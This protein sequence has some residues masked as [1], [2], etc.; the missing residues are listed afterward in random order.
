MDRQGRKSNNLLRRQRELRGWTLDR[1]AEKLDQ[2]GGGTD[3]KQV[4]KWERGLVEPSPFYKEKLCLLY[5]TNAEELGFIVS[6]A[7]TNGKSEDDQK[8]H[9]DLGSND[10]FTLKRRELLNLLSV[11]G[12][13]LILLPDLD[14]ERI[15][16]AIKKPAQIDKET[17]NDL[18]IINA[19]YWSIY[20]IAPTKAIILDGVLGQLRTL[21]EFLKSPNEAIVHKQLC[22]LVSDLAQLAGEISFDSND[23]DAAQSCYIF[24]AEA[25]KE[26]RH[27][28]LWACALIRNAYLS[29]YSNKHYEAL[30]LL[31]AAYRL[32]LRGD[33]SLTTRYWFSAVEAEAQAGIQNLSACQKA[34]DLANEVLN[35]QDT[36]S[37][38]WLR[39]NGSRLTELNGACFVKLKE[40][41]LA[42]PV[43]QKALNQQKTLR[44]RGTVLTDLARVSLQK[45]EIDQA[46]FYA[47]QVILIANQ[48]NSGMLRKGLKDLQANLTPFSKVR[49]VKNLKQQIAQLG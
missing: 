40:P 33:S 28:D 7:L 14:W 9:Q 29:I 24:A 11:A 19:R 5:G 37:V 15:G 10:M 34:L 43:L 38:A 42:W 23:Y 36:S 25:A 39:F 22:I 12:T 2:L 20:Q 17:L 31:H 47:N 8:I 30:P 26:I 35:M 27:Y 41:D 4:G 1:V 3:S 13:A 49:I 48:N 21:I 45:S 18:T 44:R 46:C 16:M 32:S 6:T